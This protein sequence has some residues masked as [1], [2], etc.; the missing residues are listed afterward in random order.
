[1]ELKC[2]YFIGIF[3]LLGEWNSP[4]CPAK[5][6]IILGFLSPETVSESLFDR[7]DIGFCNCNK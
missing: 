3:F 1:M 4:L 2:H 5:N 6:S 7:L